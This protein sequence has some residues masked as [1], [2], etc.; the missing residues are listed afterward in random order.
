MNPVTPLNELKAPSTESSNQWISTNA[1]EL[2]YGE[3]D[4]V[5]GTME[6]PEVVRCAVFDRNLH[7]RMPLVPTPLLRLKLLYACNQWHCSR[8]STFLPVPL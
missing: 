4:G 2:N 7:S 5:L 6:S 1:N 3:G 8:V